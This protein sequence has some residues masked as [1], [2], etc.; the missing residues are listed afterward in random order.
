MLPA[1]IIQRLALMESF[2]ISL[3]ILSF[4]FPLFFFNIYNVASRRFL[5]CDELV[6]SQSY[7][8]QA[9]AGTSLKGG[10]AVLRCQVPPTVKNDIQVKS[11]IQDVTGFV[12]SPSLRG[13]NHS[14]FTTLP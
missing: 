9:L 7:E 11:W 14:P 2:R 8:A 5:S 13:G 12:V 1:L 3:Y 10:L 6:L 4:F